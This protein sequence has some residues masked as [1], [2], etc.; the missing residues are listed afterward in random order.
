MFTTTVSAVLLRL[1]VLLSFTLRPLSSTS[2]LHH[3]RILHQPF[4]PQDSLPPSE[5]PIPSPP[6]PPSY[7]FSSSTPDNS[8]FFPSYPSPPPPPS[9]ASFAS[10]P[11]NISSLT[12]PET[13]KPNSSSSKLIVAAIASVVAAVVV[14]SLAVFLHLRKRARSHG[15]SSFNQSKTQRS[16]SNSTISFNQTPSTHHIPKLQRP[17]QTSSEFLYLGTLV[18]SHAPGGGAAFN[19][20][21]TS[22]SNYGNAS[23]S[24]KMES[25]ELR[26]LPPLN[27]Q[28]GFRQN[29]RSNAEV[30]SSKDDESEEFYS[31]KGSINGRESSIG[32]GSASRRAFAAI[33]VE[34]FNGSTSNSSS[35][36][37]SSAPESGSGSGSPVRSASS[38][39]S[40]ANNSNPKI[41]IPKSPE[42]TEIQSIAPLPPHMPSPQETRGLVFQ[43]S[44]SPSPPSSSSP[45]R[46]SRRS[47]ESSPRISDVSDLHVESPVRVSNP[48]QHNTTAVATEPE[49]SSLMLPESASSVPPS[50]SSPE[51][52]SR[53]SEESSERN[54]NV[55]DQKVDSPVKISSPVQ[56][57]A[58]VIPTP[59]EIQG[60]V[61]PESASSLKPPSSSSPEGFSNRSEASSPRISNA[62]DQNVG[63]PSRISS[64]VQ[65]NSVI[66]KLPE[67]QDSLFPDSGS[68]LLPRSSSPE[69]YSNRSEESSPRNSN[70]SN[71]NLEAPARISSPVENNY[72]IPTLPEMQGLMFQDSASLMRPSESSPDRYLSRSEESSPRIS[73]VSNQNVDSPSSPVHHNPVIIPPPMEMQGLVSEESSPRSSNVSEA[74]QNL[75][76]PVRINSPVH[77]NISV[78]PIPF[79]MLDMVF[80]DAALSPVRISSPVHHNI[81]VTPMPFDM[82]DIV[83]PEAAPSPVRISS[84]AHDNISV[85]P[86]PFDMF[87]SVF[88]EAAPPLPQSSSSSERC[89]ENSQESSPRNSN[90]SDQEVESPVRISSPV[91]LN[92]TVDPTPTEMQDLEFQESAFQLPLSLLSPERYS[93]RS[94]ESSPR[95]SNASDQNVESPV[96]ISTAEQNITV[97]SIPS[98][99]QGLI[100]QESALLSP[101]RSPSPER[102]S[103]RSEASSP[104]LSNVSD[105]N[106][107]SPM[108][109]SGPVQHEVTVIPAPPAPP[110]VSVPPPVPPPPPVSVPPPPPPP[111]PPSK[112][113][114]GPKTP[115]P[116]AKKSTEP[117]VLIRP[118]RP[119]AF[120]SPTLISPIELPSNDSQAVKTDGDKESPNTETEHS[121]EDTETNPKPKLK[122]LHWDKV[123]ASSDR[124]M[125]WDQLKSSSFK[126]NEEMIETLFVANTS[127][128]NPKETT[129]WQVLPSPGQDNGNRILDP[130]KAQNIAILLR[131]LHVTVDEVC[132]GLLEG[133]ADVL[134]TELLESLSKMAPSKEE[135]RKLKEHKDDSPVK[136][137]AAER[138]LKAVVDIPHAFKRVDAMLYVSNFDSEVEYLKKSFA[139]LEAACEELRTSRMFLKLLEA[140]LKTGNRMN[141]GTNRGDAHAF[142][143]DTLLKLVDVKGAD[144]KTTLLHFVVQEIIRSEGAR[145]QENSSTNDDVKCRKL[146]LQ[147]V[148]ALSSELSNVKKAA[149]MDAEVLSTDVS[150]LSRGIEN[151]REIVRL[152]ETTSLDETSGRKFSNA[153]NTLMKR[154]EEEIIR[155]QAQESV[156][157]SL[158]KEITEYFHGNSAKEEAHPFRIFMVVRD[159]LTILDRVCKEVGMINE[160]TMV[161]SAH[162]FPVPVNPML[163]QA[164]HKR[165]STSSDDESL[166]LNV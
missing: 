128:P 100:I 38:S 18:S 140:V 39:L 13:S 73:D 108:G 117:P 81:S 7:P 11:A 134:G 86:M 113:W 57:N 88:P 5:P 125:V 36:Y 25:P 148:S 114:E 165:Q 50:S 26:P 166:P 28:Q 141:V 69:R 164:F 132:E 66:L 20:S 154:A 89:S 91:Q 74:D 156:A 78:N 142:K 150:K 102:N 43:E 104:L 45:E 103:R 149:V 9:P 64:P 98:E 65:H 95:I 160:R 15:S 133:N 109:I 22:T 59:S 96:G 70:P 55:L 41:S 121:S 14:V 122:P 137:G 32:T 99:M 62:S 130:K 27:T 44:A 139:T 49:I 61:L 21:S 161:S 127:K 52:R 71:Q 107:E 144:G 53:E 145:L 136:L 34:N 162:K 1:L 116:P 115:T 67:M 157:L 92:T 77:H 110:P 80:P 75:E 79:D 76:S 40:P 146:G 56:Q 93:N 68:L 153:M 151:I 2:T 12:V 63:S 129:R 37:S 23:I 143:L 35:T 31:P 90:V 82:L 155:I 158:V 112:A 46:H 124:E 106:V 4:L 105:H 94:E 3:R 101:Q 42:L 6:S 47:E 85:T 84:P 87:D 163:Q 131:A 97:I 72:V 83:S 54:S 30:V 60:I 123:R 29:F 8:P 135:E 48:V 19:G 10:F 58:A 33:E 17:S 119:I 147:V 118:L 111:P 16:D 51:R 126:L 120:E 159:F 138:F 24:R 152:N